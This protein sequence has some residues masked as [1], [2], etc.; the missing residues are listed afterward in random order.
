MDL[1]VLK[2]LETARIDIKNQG[3]GNDVKVRVLSGEHC[4]I[5]SAP[6]FSK[7]G[8]G[9][10][11]VTEDKNF[12]LELECVGTGNLVIRMLGRYRPVS[13]NKRLPLWVDYTRL[14]INDEVIFWELKPQWHDRPYVFNRQVS[15]GEKIKVEISWS[16]HGYMGAELTEFLSLLNTTK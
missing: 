15:D 13:E 1:S 9:H 7:E 14:A 6:W 3:E 10:T 5:L 8:T 4:K 2:L 16:E 11:L 12:L